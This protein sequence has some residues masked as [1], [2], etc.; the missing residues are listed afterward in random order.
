[1]I[2]RCTNKLLAVIGSPLADPAPAPHDEDWYANLL[3]FDRRKCL[4]ATHTGTLYTI[5]EADVTASGLRAT[6]QL[7][8]GLI[9]PELRHEDLPSAT[10]GVLGQQELLLAK[11]ADRSILGCMN[12]MAFLCQHAIAGSGGLARTDLADLNRS[13]RRNINSARH[14]VLPSS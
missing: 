6:R 5:F 1:V 4:L 10:F 9:S 12:D 14:T 11:P 13:L 3:W 2:L 7:M 8:T